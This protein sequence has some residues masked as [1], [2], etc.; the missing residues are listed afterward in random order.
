MPTGAVVVTVR[1]VECASRT[2]KPQGISAEPVS[3][4][5][6]VVICGAPGCQQPGL[7]WLRGSEAMEY[8]QGNRVCFVLTR[9]RHLVKIRVKPPTEE[10]LPSRTTTPVAQP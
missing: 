10:R 7:V 9:V 4:P 2:R 6:D 1:C 5:D 3:Y 8:L